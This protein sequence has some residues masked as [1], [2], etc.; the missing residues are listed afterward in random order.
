M[1]DWLDALDG[2]EVEM[3]LEDNVYVMNT[4]TWEIWRERMLD[5]A[6]KHENPLGYMKIAAKL[7]VIIDE[8]LRTNVIEV[9]EKE[10][11]GLI[12]E[13]DEGGNSEQ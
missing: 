13:A 11:F 4:S 3:G 1:V 10:V 8:K 12:E 2:G 9:Y 7:T 6:Q 5:E